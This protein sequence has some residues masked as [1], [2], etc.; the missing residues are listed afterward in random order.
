MRLNSLLLTLTVGCA[1]GL[2]SQ[3]TKELAE[4]K[5]ALSACQVAHAHNVEAQDQCI[6]QVQKYWKM[7]WN[8]RFDGGF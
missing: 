7:R 8:S 4:Y 3:D 1:G 6:A 5:A 2:S